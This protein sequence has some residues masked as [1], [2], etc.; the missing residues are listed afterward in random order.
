MLRIYIK[1][2]KHIVVDLLHYSFN[3]TIRLHYVHQIV[4][5]LYLYNIFLN[6]SDT[7]KPHI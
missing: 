5:Y 4:W 3:N 7:N 6:L 1:R 2:K